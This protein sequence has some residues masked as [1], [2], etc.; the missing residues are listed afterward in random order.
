[1]PDASPDEA[2]VP[3]DPLLPLRDRILATLLAWIIPAIVGLLGLT[4]R[5]HVEDPYA[6]AEEGSLTNIDD[7]YPGIFVFWHRCVLPAM[8]IFR[9]R[10]L[11]V[12]TSQSR[13]GEYIAR[14]ISRM[15]YVPV[16]GSSSRGGS[17]A[18]I[19]LRRF[20]S[21]NRGVAF[22]IDGPRGP[23]YVAKRGPV[24]LARVSGVPIVAFYVA[25][26]RAWVLNTWDRFVIPKPFARLYLRGAKKII[27]PTDADDATLDLGYVEMQSALDRVTLYA[28]QQA[29]N[30]PI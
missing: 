3:N 19:E 4:W 27:V 25:A 12:V 21:E 15:G 18:M 26:D 6:S 23:R 9:R 13:D 29:G 20:V 16:R 24:V 7:L 11:A 30:P 28:E 5:F 1:M 22:T 10:N 2:S 17:R 14:V 8:W